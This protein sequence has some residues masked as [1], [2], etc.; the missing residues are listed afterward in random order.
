MTRRV[1][2]SAGEVAVRE[3]GDPGAPA[4]VLLHGFPT[5]SHLWRHLAPLLAVSFRV[6]VPDLLGAG[7]SD[8]PEGADLGLP[9]QRRYV[10]EVLEALGVGR[11]AAV[12]HGIGGGIAQLLA[13]EGRVEALVLVDTAAFEAWPSEATREAQA[14]APT[15]DADLVAAAIRAA[16]GLGCRRRGP[17]GPDLDEYLRPFVGAS[18]ARAFSR[19]LLSLDGRGLEGAAERIGEREVPTLVLWGEEDP[20]FPVALAERLGEAIP[21]ASLALLPGCGHFLPEEAPGT[22][23][24]LIAEYLRSRYLGRPHAHGV[25]PIP[26]EL[27]R[28]PDEEGRR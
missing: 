9:A 27:L 17:E 5:S 8:K 19:W 25:G 28:R 6:L 2:T 21:T 23:F 3:L 20:F 4:V 12:G 7:D 24:P 1:R 14:H 26:V 16:F 13:A 15:E 22:I 10:S 18:G 11:L